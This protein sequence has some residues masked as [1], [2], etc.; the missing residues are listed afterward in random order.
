MNNKKA[1][2]FGLDARIA[3]AIFGALSVISG[4]ALYSAIQKT[5]TTS[6]I[7]TLKEIEK[8]IIAYYIDT[9]A[10]LTHEIDSS[11]QVHLSKLESDSIPGWSGPYFSDKLNGDVITTQYNNI[12]ARLGDII[13]ANSET[14]VACTIRDI[15]EKDCTIWLEWYAMPKNI[16][17]D[18]DLTIDGS[19][20]LT[21]GSIRYCSVCG[22]GI[23]SLF[24]KV[25]L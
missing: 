14:R 3:L 20:D 2:M 5:K 9:G 16:S 18:I 21:N 11:S 6:A 23:G 19:A 24:Y 12:Y 4:A 13:S 17:E 15:Y 25:D 7:V 1:A 8:S 10:L 22:G